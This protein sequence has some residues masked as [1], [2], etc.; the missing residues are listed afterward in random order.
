M[1]QKIMKC[2]GLAPI[3]AMVASHHDIMQNEALIALAAMSSMVGG[4]KVTLLLQ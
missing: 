3:V 2:G 1:S 4:K